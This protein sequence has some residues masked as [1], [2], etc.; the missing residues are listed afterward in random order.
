MPIDATKDDDVQNNSFNDPQVHDRQRMVFTTWNTFTDAKN[1]NAYFQRQVW[2]FPTTLIG[3]LRVPMFTL[4]GYGAKHLVWGL[5][6]VAPVWV[7]ILVG[8]LLAL[9]FISGILTVLL[10]D[11]SLTPG[12]AVYLFFTLFGVL[13]P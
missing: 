9:P 13:I 2:S 3:W 7:P 5:Y 10:E 1:T 6:F 11:M 8:V 4:L 12:L